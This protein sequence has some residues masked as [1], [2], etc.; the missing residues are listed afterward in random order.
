MFTTEEQP[1]TNV[2]E[3][4]ADKERL[5]AEKDAMIAQLRERIRLLEKALFGPRSERIVEVGNQLEFESMLKELEQL[6]D[7]LEDSEKDPEPPA[8]RTPSRRRR[9]RRSLEELIPEDLPEEQIVIDLSDEEKIDPKTGEQM[10]KVG[11][12][13]VVKLGVTPANYKRV[14]FVYFKYAVP[15]EALSGVKQAAAPD[16]AIPGGIYDESF[17]A[18]VVFDKCAMHLPLYRQAE[19]LNNLGIDISRQT[20]SHLYIETAEVLTPLYDIMKEEIIS[21]GVI[22][23]DDTPVRLQ[24]KGKGKTV[25]GRMWVYV[26]GGTGPPYRVFEFTR[27]RSKKRPKEF[28][29]GFQGY[30]HADAYQGYDDLFDLDGVYECG[31]WM[32]VRRKFVEAV[33]A[34]EELRE[35]ILRLIRLMYRYERVLKDKPDEV[36]VAVRQERTAQVIDTIF[37]RTARALTE[38]QVLPQSSF[39]KAIGYMHNLGDALRTFL[40]DANL[41]PDNGESERAIRPLAIGRRNWLFAGSKRGGDATGVLLSLIQS[42]R[43]M[44]IDPQVYL[45]DVLRRINGHPYSRIDELLPGNWQKADSYY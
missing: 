33:D 21:R 14:V 10:V 6:S 16:F 4:L 19:R 24:V 39:A 17:L 3:A 25:T 27:D 2:A 34:P 40:S 23:T 12:E 43:I 15:G 18:S 26:G 32:H 30:I 1:G 20:L 8:P 45:E 7:A 29:K 41:K 37:E 44:D 42:C 13:R 36:V 22:F 9:R 11:E 5:L 35:E 38:G 31:C 28:L